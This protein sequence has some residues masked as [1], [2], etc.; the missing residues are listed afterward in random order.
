MEINPSSKRAGAKILEMFGEAT[1]SHHLE[2][3]H[4]SKEDGVEENDQDNS[5]TLILFEEV[6]ILFDEDVGF[7]KAVKT[8]METTKRPIVLTCN[9]TIQFVIL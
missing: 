5:D 2:K 3:W 8:L 4:D 1:Q 9:S 6:D 7:F